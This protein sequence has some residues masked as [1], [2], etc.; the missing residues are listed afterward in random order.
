MPLR[1]H[2]DGSGNDL[3]APAGLAP[4]SAGRKSIMLHGKQGRTRAAVPAWFPRGIALLHDPTLNKGT[5]FTDAER[6]ALGLR[7]Q[8]PPPVRGT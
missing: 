1:C 3:I 2:P 6:D 4:V 5:A 7:G 8:L